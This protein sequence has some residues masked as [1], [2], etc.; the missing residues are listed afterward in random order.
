MLRRVRGR[1]GLRRLSASGPEA[2][3]AEAGPN[4]AALLRDEGRGRPMG[5]RFATAGL[6]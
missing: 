4:I 1:G 6:S 3:F 5:G 2:S